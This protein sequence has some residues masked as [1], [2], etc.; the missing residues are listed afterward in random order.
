MFARHCSG[1]LS[2][3]YTG[4]STVRRLFGAGNGGGSMRDSSVFLY[5]RVSSSSRGPI[6]HHLAHVDPCE[7]INKFRVGVKFYALGI[8]NV[9]LRFRGAARCDRKREQ[10]SQNELG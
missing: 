8:R 9:W 3:C 1:D 10:R 5:D 7:R 2:N 6:T 4:R